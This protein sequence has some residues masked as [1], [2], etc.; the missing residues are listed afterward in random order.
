MEYTF[1]QMDRLRRRWWAWTVSSLSPSLAYHLATGDYT[2]GR[3]SLSMNII[4]PNEQ[5]EVI[6]KRQE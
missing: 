2:I 6:K 4:V 1:K 5:R 3:P